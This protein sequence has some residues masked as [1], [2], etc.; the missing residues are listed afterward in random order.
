MKNLICSYDKN[1]LTTEKLENS[2]Y[3]ILKKYLFLENHCFSEEVLM[4]A[5]QGASWKQRV[6]FVRNQRP[7]FISA[8]FYGSS[9][10]QEFHHRI[11]W[12][13]KYG[14][15]DWA[16]PKHPGVIRLKGLADAINNML[17]LFERSLRKLQQGRLYKFSYCKIS[18]HSNSFPWI[19]H[20]SYFSGHLSSAVFKFWFLSLSL[21]LNDI[22][23][24]MDMIMGFKM[25]WLIKAG[26]NDSLWYAN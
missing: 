23:W 24:Y 12:K 26:R 5:K 1:N 14:L 3:T 21:I 15:W 22:Y 10:F 8:M 2:S 20:I 4:S 18:L 6:Y 25:S 11:L 13:A 19:L 7:R 9:M 17:E 16:I